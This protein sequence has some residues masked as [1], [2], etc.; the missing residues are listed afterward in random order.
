MEEL[1]GKRRSLCWSSLTCKLSVG[2]PPAS[3]LSHQLPV[4]LK[5]EN[6]AGFVVY[7]DDVSV[8]IHGHA[9]RTHEPASTDLSLQGRQPAF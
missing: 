8:L 4:G 5:D 7:G 3:K 6:A 9:L 2:R 1:G